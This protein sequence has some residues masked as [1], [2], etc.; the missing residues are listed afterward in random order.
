MNITSTSAFKTALCLSGLL[1]LPLA[2]ANE[3]APWLLA[4]YD[5]NGDDKITQEEIARKRQTLFSRMDANEDGD[6]SF[7]EYQLTD[8]ARRAALL[9]A[10]FNK[11]DEDHNGQVSE[12]EYASFLGMFNSFDS[13]GD[14]AL[15]SQEVELKPAEG[16]QVTR[17]LLWFCLRTDL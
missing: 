6:I 14:G 15:T 2:Q 8:Q 13:N 4:K 9:K 3:S 12:A 16:A 7:E 5:L 11:L 1:A 17:C 10:R